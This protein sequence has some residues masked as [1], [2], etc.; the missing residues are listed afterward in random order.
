MKINTTQQI[1]RQLQDHSPKNTAA[2]DA[3]AFGDALGRAL[4]TDTAG[5]AAHAGA[6]AGMASISGVQFTSQPMPARITAGEK[7]EQ[8]LELLEDYQQKLAEPRHSLKSIA[9]QLARMEKGVR[10]LEKVIEKIDDADGLKS[11]AQEA[12]ITATAE[13]FKF[14][15]GDYIPT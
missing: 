14:N 4:N 13:M 8:L 6:P 2:A 7:I 9:P 1:L 3:R 12:L 5:K 15:R 11:I 10:A